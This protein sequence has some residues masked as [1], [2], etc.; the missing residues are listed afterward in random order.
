[1]HR[2]LPFVV[3]LFFVVGCSSS[4]RVVWKG[5][6]GSPPALLPTPPGFSVTPAQAE[7]AARASRRLPV[8]V[9]YHVYADSQFY[10]VCDG[11]FGSSRR[12]AV[13]QG[14]QIDGRTGQMVPR[15]P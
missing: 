15:A 11:F 9:V 10:Y 5:G 3:V 2:I 12:A 1:M 14:L 13:K 7:A 6:S 8:K 4:P